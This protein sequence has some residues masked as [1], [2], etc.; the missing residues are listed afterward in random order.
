MDEVKGLGQRIEEFI[1][2]ELSKGELV[3]KEIIT[4]AMAAIPEAGHNT[5][6]GTISSLSAAKKIISKGKGVWALP[7]SNQISEIRQR[8]RKVKAVR[9]N[10]TSVNIPKRV[11]DRFNNNIQRFAEHL[12]SARERDANEADTG[13]IVEDIL[14]QLLGYKRYDEVTCELHVRG[15][16]CD[17]AIRVGGKIEFLVEVKRISSHLKQNHRDQAVNYGANQGTKWVI[18]TNGS[19]WQLYQ[20]TFME[21]RIGSELVSSFDFMALKPQQNED[22]ERLFLLSKEGLAKNAREMYF[23]R[24]Q[25]VNRFVLGSLILTKPVLWVIRSELRKVSS[26]MIGIDEVEQIIR[27]EV[28][29]EEIVEGQEAKEALARMKRSRRG[30]KP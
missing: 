29:R 24:T 22:L 7:D 19:E 15:N 4:R 21:Q 20:I 6:S 27:T 23:E 10:R 13:N 9:K 28:L 16:R 14:S 18:L 17:Y 8:P 25:Q 12:R 30:R 26:R 2:N 5:V 11:V 3:R 1:L